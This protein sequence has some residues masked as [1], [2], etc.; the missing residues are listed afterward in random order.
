MSGAITVNRLVSSGQ[1]S[2]P[3]VGVEG[4]SVYEE[5]VG[6]GALLDEEHVEP[7]VVEVLALRLPLL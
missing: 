1:I 4:V 5:E 6:P 2:D 3:V 7:Q